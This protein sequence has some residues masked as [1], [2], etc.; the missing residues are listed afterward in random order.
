MVKR[1]LPGKIEKDKEKG[2][3]REGTFTRETEC[4]PNWI[5]EG[6]SE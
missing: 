5:Q 4:E 1:D 3:G 6:G 2:V